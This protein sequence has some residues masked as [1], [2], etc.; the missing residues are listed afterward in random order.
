MANSLYP[1]GREGFLAGDIDWDANDIRA[2]LRDEGADAYNSADDNL[3]DISAGARI[4]VM[5]SGATGKTTTA[6]TADLDDI[7]FSAVSGATVESVDFYK[8]TGTES[9]SRL[10][11]NIDTATG[12]PFTPSG[13]DV[14]FRVDNGANKLFTL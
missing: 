10:I 5:G 13:G 14:I 9:T 3:D 1:S 2:L 8:H 12:L 7:T 6:G 4:A 11:C